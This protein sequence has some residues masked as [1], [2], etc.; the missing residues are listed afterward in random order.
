MSDFQLKYL[1]DKV[2]VHR[3]P[4]DSPIWDDST[5]S[6][7]DSSINKNPEKKQITVNETTVQ[8]E[9]IIF[10]SLNR[11]G[12]TIPLFKDECTM[13]FEGMLGDLSAHVHITIKHG[14]FLGIFN[15]LIAWRQKFFPSS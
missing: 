2:H 9:N 7:L 6:Q 13:I 12:L 10:Y 11:I 14:N 3:W 15:Q 4:Q 1:A 5:I 8:I